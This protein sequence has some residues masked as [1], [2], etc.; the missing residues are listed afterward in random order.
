MAQ[1]QPS[2][3]FD[4]SVKEEQLKLTKGDRVVLY[5]D[6]VVEAMNAEKQQFGEK[7]FYDLARQLAPQNSETFVQLTVQELERH[8]GQAE[9]HDDITIST[10]VFT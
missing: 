5:T 8:R 1:R 10:F 4:Q 7:R 9:Q 2:P 3:V 6:G